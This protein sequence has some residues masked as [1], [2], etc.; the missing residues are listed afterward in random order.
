MSRSPIIGRQRE[1]TLLRDLVDRVGARGAAL[2]LTGMPG[3]GKSTLLDEVREVAGDRDMVVLVTSGV[4][5]EADLPFA[6]LHRLLR[7]LLP[8]LPGLPA[9]QRQAVEVAFGITAGPPPE[10]FMIALAV[11]GLLSEAA[12]RSPLLIIVDD[13]HWLDR[14]SAD[15]LAFLA[16]RIESDPI[17]LLVAL[18]EGYDNPLDQPGSLGLR[19]DRLTDEAAGD[20]LRRTR[21]DLPS[22][23]RRRILA[24]AGENPLALHE[25]NAEPAPRLSLTRSLERAFAT[26]VA[27]LPAPDRTLV[28]VAATAE[29]AAL[30]TILAAAEMIDG[31]ARTVED[32][33]LPIRARILR[34]EGSG[35]R[36]RH[37]LVR[38]AVY[39]S[40]TVAE[41][42]AAHTALA[43]LLADD[44]DRRAWHRW[45]AALRPDPEISAEVEEAGRRAM[46]RGAAATAALAFERAAG[47]ATETGRRGRLLLQAAAAAGELGDGETVNRLLR[48][49]ASRELGPSERARLMWL[50]DSFWPGSVGDPARVRELVAM[51]SRVAALGEA[52]LALNL[53][54]SAAS[55]CC[56]GGLTTEGLEVARA[57]DRIGATG[58]PRMLFILAFA[59]PFERGAAVLRDHGRTPTPDD[60]MA[61]YLRGAAVGLAGAFD[62]AVPLLGAAARQL[63]EQ[64]QLRLLAQVLA[65]RAW[66]SLEVGDLKVA[67]PAAEEAVRLAAETLA[68]FW[69]I[70]ALI[71]RSVIAAFQGDEATVE[72]ATTEAERIALPVGAGYLV[73]LI[74]YAR[75]LLEL[76]RGRHTQAYDHLR[77]VREPGDPAHNE[78]CAHH[79]IGDFTEA[80][81]RSGHRA[82]AEAA[83]SAGEATAALARSPWIDIQ[84]LL[85]RAHLADAFG[86]A[87]SRDLSGWP[88]I[89]AR[90]DLAHGESLRRHRRLVESRA[91]LRAARDAFDTIGAAPWAERA[92]QELRAAG[93]GSR[94]PDPDALGRLTPQEVQ[95]VEMVADGLSNGAIAERLY[96]S[97]RTIESHLYRVFPKL[98]VTSRGQLTKVLGDRS[99]Q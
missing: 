6:G 40:A 15:V 13:A 38:S 56:W 30:A 74:Q 53:L 42:H 11:L 84:M 62:Q 55:R 85:A 18:R 60:P 27:E 58:D 41:R 68:P 8:E 10:P 26:R 9:P 54:M 89:R 80:A 77:R 94:E 33:D 4:A 51:A 37:P 1:S 90:L 48:D 21:P 81:V 49:A 63:R 88:V 66:T 79:T 95:I 34:V 78:L 87:L 19:L 59:T 50:E 36:F 28:V 31:S 17:V 43:E 23:V 44:P 39:Q 14:P 3:I 35:V 97:R 20:L 73:G 93:E 7:P 57:A 98:G 16:R 29:E 32:L 92:R 72:T 12:A 5:S 83:V 47:M 24:E 71:A 69:R 70:G 99:V 91:P 67:A 61:L 76:G 64:G 45:A 25:L 2:V 46:Y 82:E 22:A 52:D 86:D 96:L 65:M 75:G